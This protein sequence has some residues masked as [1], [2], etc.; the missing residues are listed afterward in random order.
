MGPDRSYT[1]RDLTNSLKKRSTERIMDRGGVIN[2]S[3]SHRARK[4]S[5]LTPDVISRDETEYGFNI[6]TKESIGG[7]TQETGLGGDSIL[8]QSCSV[9]L[10]DVVSL[11][12]KT[13]LLRMFLFFPSTI[14]P[15]SSFSLSLC[16]L[17]CGPLTGL[18]H[19]LAS[20]STLRESAN[21]G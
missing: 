16:L 21:G 8:E 12:Q 3:Q 17:S 13:L 19:L 2:S 20:K 11:F 18:P 14:R 1:L 4:P 10:Q 9:G 5:A 7:E 15:G 6:Q